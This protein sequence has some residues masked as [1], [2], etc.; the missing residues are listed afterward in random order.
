MSHD[1]SNTNLESRTVVFKEG[2]WREILRLL[3]RATIIESDPPEAMVGETLIKRVRQE[4]ADRRKRDTIFGTGLFGE[5]A[6]DILLVLFIEKHGRRHSIG[7]LAKL[8]GVAPTTA[9]RWIEALERRDLI[10]RSPHPT[11]LRAVFV[12]MT[13][14]GERAMVSYFSETL[15]RM[16]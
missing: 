16:R 2:D 5:P 15:T 7:Q 8:S 10:R 4:F 13:E 14:E 9:L 11:D 3:G 6:W 12:E 1:S